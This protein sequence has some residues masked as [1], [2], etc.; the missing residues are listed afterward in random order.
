MLCITFPCVF[1]L[2]HALRA[3]PYLLD[4][5]SASTGAFE[6]YRD[7]VISAVSAFLEGL[8]GKSKM[9]IIPNQRNT[10]RIESL[11]DINVSPFEL[12]PVHLRVGLLTNVMRRT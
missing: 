1:H 7:P 12:L 8:L 5:R 2:P 9:S 3:K 6:S 11:A 4:A 10:Q